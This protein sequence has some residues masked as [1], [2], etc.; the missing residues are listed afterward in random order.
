[1]EDKSNRKNTTRLMERQKEVEETLQRNLNHPHVKA[2]HIFLNQNNAE[3]RLNS[4]DLRNKQKLVVRPYTGMPTYKHFA[5]YV[6]QRLTN[7]LIAITNM[8]IYLG[9]GFEKINVRLMTKHNIAYA[10]TRSGKKERRCYMNY[11]IGRCE[12]NPYI[13][14]H[15]TY[16]MKLKEP[17]CNEV[18]EMLTNPMN[19][20][21]AEKKWFGY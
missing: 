16:I 18:L 17:V 13:G 12:E 14:S 2:L 4:L 20:V 11:T 7:E 8:D 19:R 21:G 6:N 3:E 10:L 5:S 9:E 1:M 15:D